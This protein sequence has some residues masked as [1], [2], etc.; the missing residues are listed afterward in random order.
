MRGGEVVGVC[1]MDFSFSQKL[2]LPLRLLLLL[3]LSSRKMLKSRFREIKIREKREKTK[4]EPIQKDGARDRQKPIRTILV[5][6][7][8]VVAVWLTENCDLKFRA[9]V[10][11]R[12][13]STHTLSFLTLLNSVTR[14][15]YF[16]FLFLLIAVVNHPFLFPYD[17][18]VRPAL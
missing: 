9:F 14:K 10:V 1:R 8:V 11:V 12:R 7:V 2:W 6:L 3:L 5:V 17:F 13:V 4:Q 16:L 15:E 18:E